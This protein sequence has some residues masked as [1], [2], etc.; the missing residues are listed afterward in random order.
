MIRPSRKARC[1]AG[2]IVAQGQAGL[3]QPARSEFRREECRQ[4]PVVRNTGPANLDARVRQTLFVVAGGEIRGQVSPQVHAI[5]E[6]LEPVALQ[7]TQAGCV[8]R[9]EPGG[10]VI[11]GNRQRFHRG[12]TALALLRE[13][14]LEQAAGHA[15]AA[16]TRVR[17]KKPNPPAGLGQPHH[18]LHESQDAPIRDAGINLE[19]VNGWLGIVKELLRQQGRD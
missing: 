10:K 6:A 8:T 11:A 12:Q 19:P 17:S 16:N 4:Q 13:N 15:L 5:A 14:M 3:Q 7:Q 18:R 2:G 1:S 9:I